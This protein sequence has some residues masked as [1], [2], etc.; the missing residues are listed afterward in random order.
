MDKIISYS[1][2]GNE[3]KYIDGAIWNALNYK[4]YFPDWKARFYIREPIAP[5]IE[6]I[7]AKHAE[8]EVCESDAK[9]MYSV[10]FLPLVDD[11]TC[12]VRDVDSRFTVRDVRCVKEWLESD[13]K[14]HTIRDHP[15]HIDEQYPIQGGLWGKRGVIENKLILKLVKHICETET[16]LYSDQAWLKNNIWK[17]YHDQFMIH[18]YDQIPWMRDSWSEET[19][20]GRR[21]E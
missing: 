11:S 15:Y 7:L 10:R 13:K 17:H 19:H 12:I 4:A 5:E 6:A 1:L 18:Q 8:I 16:K 2:F 21:Y 3:K 20:C 9:N 14:F